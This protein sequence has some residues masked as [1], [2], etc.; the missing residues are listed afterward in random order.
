VTASR[1]ISSRLR[2]IYERLEG[3]ERV[4]FDRRYGLPADASRVVGLEGLGYG[5]PGRNDYA[6]SSW[7]ALRRILPK[8]EVSRDD[9]F[10]D[11]GCGMGRAILAASQYPFKR[12]IGIDIVPDFTQ[13]AQAVVQRNRHRLR[14]NEIELVT[15]DAATWAVP[16]D[17]TVVHLFD[18]F[19]G[20]VLDAV[21]SQLLASLD[22]RERQLRVIFLGPPGYRPLDDVP[23]AR[24]VRH[25]RRALA[26]WAESD[27][28]SLYELLAAGS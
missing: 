24:L 19:R 20:D 11:I 6:A 17:V 8:H 5:A 23:R 10:L 27:Y 14:C 16:D 15:A 4:I 9:V 25:G 21:L 7:N 3:L 26:R 1:F 18:P 28:L 2:A 22:R 12:I 13:I